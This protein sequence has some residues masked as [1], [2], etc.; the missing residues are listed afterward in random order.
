MSAA[1]SEA[2]GII[3]AVGGVG[4]LSVLLVLA[5]KPVKDEGPWR[6]DG[7]TF[8]GTGTCRYR[9]TST[10]QRCCRRAGHR[11]RHD[12]ALRTEDALAEQSARVSNRR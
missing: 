9:S 8:A 10:G 5:A 6:Y 7:R 1:M 2:L 12:G 3:L 4:G 11:G